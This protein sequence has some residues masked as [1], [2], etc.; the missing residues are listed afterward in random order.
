[1]SD[2]KDISRFFDEPGASPSEFGR[3]KKNTPSSVSRPR[4]NKQPTGLRIDAD[5]YD[6][7]RILKWK[8]LLPSMTATLDRALSEFKDN[9]KVELDEAKTQLG[10][11]GLRELL[12]K[13]D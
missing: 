6:E 2:D 4:R 12:S 11:N 5:L 13:K 3:S 1:M 10:E 8:M 7:L 9:H